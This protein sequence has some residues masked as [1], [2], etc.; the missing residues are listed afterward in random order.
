MPWTLGR[1][2]LGKIVRKGGVF[3]PDSSGFETAFRWIVILSSIPT[4]H[5]SRQRGS[6][7]QDIKHWR[8]QAGDAIWRFP[9][10]WRYPNSWMVYNGTLEHLIKMDDLGVPPFFGSTFHLHKIDSPVR[11]RARTRNFAR[12]AIHMRQARS[13][14]GSSCTS[15]VQPR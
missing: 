8:K 4:K 13:W 14:A 5:Q 11:G 7:H 9:N 10:G 15:F 2:K 12:L 1:R 3:T 6:E